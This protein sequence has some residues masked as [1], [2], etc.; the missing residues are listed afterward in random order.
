MEPSV[1][2]VYVVMYLYVMFEP[3]KQTV[4]NSATTCLCS[5]VEQLMA[6]LWEYT[7]NPKPST[8]NPRGSSSPKRLQVAYTTTNVEA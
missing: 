2:K 8:P 5:I 3:G 4:L 6:N 1:I 7:L